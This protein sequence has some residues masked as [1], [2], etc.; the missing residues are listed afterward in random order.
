MKIENILISKE[1]DIKI[2]DFGLSNL[3]SPRAQLSTFCGSL[4]FAAPE[5]L[6][7]KAYTGPEVDVWSFGIVLYVLVCGKVPFDDQSMPA[8]HAKI[9][10]GIVEYPSFISAGTLFRILSWP[11]LTLPAECKHLISRMLV[12]PSSQRAT[13]TEIIN[14]PWMVKGLETPIDSHTI[15]RQPLTLPLDS[16]VIDGMTGFDFGTRDEIAQK[17]TDVVTSDDYKRSSKFFNA[18]Q[19][20]HTLGIERRESKFRKRD[21]TAYPTSPVGV[22]PVNGHYFE[23]TMILDPTKAYHPLLSIY[24]LV[25]EKQARNRKEKEH[26]EGIILSTNKPELALQIPTIPM[27]EEAHAGETSYEIQDKPPASPIRSPTT[28]RARSRTHGELEMRAAVKRMSLAPPAGPVMPAV[29]AVKKESGFGLLRRLSSRRY[30]KEAVAANPEPIPVPSPNVPAPTPVLELGSPRKKPDETIPISP[31]PRAGSS[32]VRATSASEAKKYMNRRS[33]IETTGKTD[34][35]SGFKQGSM[36]RPMPEEAAPRSMRAKSLG[37][38]RGDE[39][40]DKR[41]KKNDL[42]ASPIISSIPEGQSVNGLSASDRDY[43]KPVS[44][45]GLFSVSTTSTKGAPAIRSDLLRTLDQLGVSH[46]EIK[47]GYTCIH[48]P[49]IDVAANGDRPTPEPA[50]LSDLHRTP[51]KMRRRLSFAR[52]SRPR[53]TSSTTHRLSAASES[54]DSMME[55]MLDSSTALRFEVYIVKISWFNLRGVQ[56]KRVSGNSWQ[57]KNLASKILSE[58]RL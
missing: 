48:R 10:R 27:P 16:D 17:L 6:N 22:G 42:M 8:L 32:V 49:S 33:M 34:E 25:E 52:S 41:A 47:G 15:S 14:H 18:M 58:L 29:Q 56:F 19:N 51:S 50:N 12:V 43:V 35:S 37:H 26:A 11:G 39:L 57:Y 53:S 1:G 28:P 21:S 4:Y 40:Q 45:K 23:N 44:L 13:M 36:L 38:V 3:Y 20:D 5:L 30:R 46:T 31:Q 54:A 7:A 9:K 55:D 24:Y 2:I